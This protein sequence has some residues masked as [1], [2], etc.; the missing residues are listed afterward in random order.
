MLKYV[1]VEIWRSEGEIYF[2]REILRERR[3]VSLPEGTEEHYMYRP[4]GEWKQSDFE[5]VIDLCALEYGER[6][7]ERD[8]EELGRDQIR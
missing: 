8:R 4:K 3:R 6:R 7:G 1:G 2:N 5:Q